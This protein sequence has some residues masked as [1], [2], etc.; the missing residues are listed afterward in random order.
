MK[1]FKKW[2]KG[3][4]KIVFKNECSYERKYGKIGWR[5]ALEEVLGWLDHSAEHKEIKDKIHN[6]LEEE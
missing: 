1:Y 2:W 6:E 3:Y 4:S 5:A